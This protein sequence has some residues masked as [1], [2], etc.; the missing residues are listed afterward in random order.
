L[1]Q[2]VQRVIFVD[3]QNELKQL[4]QLPARVAYITTI[5]LGL[6]TIACVFH[7]DA[8]ISAIFIKCLFYTRPNCVSVLC[9][10]AASEAQC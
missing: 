1:A 4:L 9:F 10:C 7:F 8:Y 3:Y 5:D 2:N 6:L